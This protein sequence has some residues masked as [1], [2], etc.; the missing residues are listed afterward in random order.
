MCLTNA[1]MEPSRIIMGYRDISGVQNGHQ[2]KPE[3]NLKPKVVLK[4]HIFIL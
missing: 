2:L 3:E 1:D 4:K